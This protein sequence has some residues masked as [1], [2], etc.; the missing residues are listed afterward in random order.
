[1]KIVTN[2]QWMEADFLEASRFFEDAENLNV[3]HTHE[4]NGDKL[5]DFVKIGE[6]TYSRSISKV[7]SRHKSG[8][9]DHTAYSH[10]NC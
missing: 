5:L 1:M 3:E 4:E 7:L 6:K 9:G 10:Y 2:L 8:V